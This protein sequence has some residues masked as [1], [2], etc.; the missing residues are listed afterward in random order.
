[1]QEIF[2]KTFVD[3][4]QDDPEAR[5]WVVLVQFPIAAAVL[6]TARP[7]RDGCRDDR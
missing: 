2:Y 5:A 3:A 7:S 6:N 4:V 1:L